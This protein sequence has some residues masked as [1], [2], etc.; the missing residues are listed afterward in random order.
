MDFNN[1]NENGVYTEIVGKVVEVTPRRVTVAV[2]YPDQSTRWIEF[3]CTNVYRPELLQLDKVQ[4]VLVS[5]WLAE[6]LQVA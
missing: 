5:L 3:P 4:S 1:R 2:H 6:H